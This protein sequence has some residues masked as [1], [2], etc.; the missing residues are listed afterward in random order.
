[1][2]KNELRIGNFVFRK[3]WNPHPTD[4][5]YCFDP[6]EVVA[7]GIDKIHVR[8][9]SKEILKQPSEN[10]SPIPLSE[11][12][13]LKLGFEKEKQGALHIF[14]IAHKTEHHCMYYEVSLFGKK[15]SMSINHNI[16]G[17]PR[18]SYAFAWDIEYVHQMQNVFFAA[19][20]QELIVK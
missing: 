6:N 5:S 20:K 2:I 11:E 15:A 7:V 18:S 10:I 12:W 16:S 14:K 3:W 1:M 19:T 13:L 8:L 4:P 9:K 17:E